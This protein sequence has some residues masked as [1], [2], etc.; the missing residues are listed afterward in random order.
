MTKICTKCRK[1]KPLSEFSIDKKKKDGFRTSCKECNHNYYLENKEKIN[2][3]HKNWQSKN[4]DYI[5]I[6]NRIIKYGVTLEQYNKML[7][8]QNG[9]CAICGQVEKIIDKRVNRTVSLAVDHNHSTGKVRGLLCV[10]CNSILGLANDN[11]I[12]LQKSIEYLK[13]EDKLYE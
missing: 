10:K 4:K 6:Y 11:M 7:E 9:V 1:E 8:A 13:Q 5:K 3:S 2:L 12:L